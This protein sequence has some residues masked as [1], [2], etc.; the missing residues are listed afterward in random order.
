[1]NFSFE[2]I[3]TMGLFYFRISRC[4]AKA[5]GDLKAEKDIN[6]TQRYE[7]SVCLLVLQTTR[8]SFR[9]L[10]YSLKR[11]ATATSLVLETVIRLGG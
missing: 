4:Q 8:S 1:M 10:S 2:F 5:G 6:L 11:F 7:K 3:C 9:D